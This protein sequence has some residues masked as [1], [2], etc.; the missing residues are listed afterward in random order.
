MPTIKT[1]YVSGN[2]PERKFS[3]GALVATVWENQGK[4]K[5][6]EDVSY[7]TISLQRRYKDEKG[8]WKSTNSFRLNDLPKASL[9]LQKAYEYFVLK[10]QMRN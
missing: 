10:E 2:L 1:E 7:K 8:E 5:E 3:T 9:V 4:S 6:G